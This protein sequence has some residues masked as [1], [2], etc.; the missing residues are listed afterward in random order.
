MSDQTTVDELVRRAHEAQEA[1]YASDFV[2]TNAALQ[3]LIDEVAPEHQI[4]AGRDLL[5]SADP[6]RRVLG[7]RLLRETYRRR[8]EALGLIVDALERES[9]DDA[10]GWL[11]SAVAFVGDPSAIH[12]VRPFAAH[13]SSFVRD[14][15]ASALSRCGAEARSGPA[16]DALLTLTDDPDRE[17]RFSSL[18]EIAQWWED[19][20]RDPRIERRLRQA[21]T[22]DDPRVRRVVEEAFASTVRSPDSSA[23]QPDE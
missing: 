19:G 12:V 5:A 8:A 10:L 15:A 14:Q 7:A 20:C 16:L 13:P 3:S 1:E 17:V 23:E 6:R 21:L 4:E 9:D 18:F 11:V 2:S 22:E